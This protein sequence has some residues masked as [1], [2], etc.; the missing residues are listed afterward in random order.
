MNDAAQVALYCSVVIYGYWTTRG[1]A[2]LRIAN[3]RTGQ[4]ADWTSCGLVNL[5]TRQLADW[6]SDRLDNSWKCSGRSW[7]GNG[8]EI[9]NNRKKLALSM[10]TLHA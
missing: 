6:A 3:W 7:S 1:Y 9:R 10:A 2:K 4:L 8:V 5:Q